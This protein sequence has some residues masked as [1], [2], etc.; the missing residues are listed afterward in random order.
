MDAFGDEEDC[1]EAVRLAYVKPIIPGLLMANRNSVILAID[2]VRLSISGDDDVLLPA[3]GGADHAVVKFSVD[4]NDDIV[5]GFSE[6]GNDDQ[7]VRISIGGGDDRTERFSI[8]GDV[9]QDVR[10][11]MGVGDDQDVR[12]SVGVDDNRE[13]GVSVVGGD[14]GPAVRFSLGGDKDVIYESAVDRVEVSAMV[15]TPGR[16]SHRCVTFTVTVAAV[17]VVVIISKHDVAQ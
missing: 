9:D 15:A 3:G 1:L 17:A 4:R 11:S 13:A 2:D 10:F 5:V 8:G 14:D 16:V 12:F 6:G 7:D